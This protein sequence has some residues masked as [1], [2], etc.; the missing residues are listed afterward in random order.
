MRPHL[1]RKLAD[2]MPASFA[3]S[4]GWELGVG[5]RLPLKQVA[6]LGPRTSM[7]I[8]DT[9]K[10]DIHVTGAGTATIS[11]S[12]HFIGDL[13]PYLTCSEGTS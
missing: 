2:A 9:Y 5:W 13:S 7:I 4:E 1:L 10:L 6:M 3:S 11:V 8:G 12:E